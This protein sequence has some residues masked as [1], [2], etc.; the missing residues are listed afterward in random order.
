M[1]S[2]VLCV[3]GMTPAEREELTPAPT[4]ADEGDWR[5]RIRP[6]AIVVFRRA[7]GAI[8]AAP[9][10]DNVKQQRFYRPLGGEIEFWER[11]EDAA[12]REIREEVGAEI[13]GL[14]LLGVEE[15]IFTYLGARGH[16]LVWTFEASFADSSF[17]ERD[18]VP[19]LEGDAAFEAHW[20]PLSLFERGEAPLYPEGLL[21][22]LTKSE[23][24]AL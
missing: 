21:D 9:G 17:Y 23:S 20:V 15:N 22:V 16:E 1:R 14:K 5:N 2:G 7:D 4:A 13:T 12:R 8:L 10:Y 18:V 3:P 11:A 19:C 24:Q 6:I